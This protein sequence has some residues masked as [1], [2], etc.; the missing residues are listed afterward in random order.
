MTYVKSRIKF[1]K[2]NTFNNVAKFTKNMVEN[3]PAMQ[4]HEQQVEDVVNGKS[5]AG[6]AVKDRIP[7]SGMFSRMEE[8]RRNVQTKVKERT[9]VKLNLIRMALRKNMG[10][11]VEEAIEAY[12]ERNRKCWANALE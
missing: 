4:E 3:S 6:K 11:I 8:S 10:D 9:Y 1:N 5:Y 2:F 7:Q 12:V